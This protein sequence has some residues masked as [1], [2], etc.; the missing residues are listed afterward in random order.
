MLGR[1][2]RFIAFVSGVALAVIATAQAAPLRLTVVRL[3]AAAKPR[4]AALTP[5]FGPQTKS[6]IAKEAARE[7]GDNTISAE[8]AHTAVVNSGLGV[9]SSGDID[10]LVEAVLFQCNAD[11]EDDLRDQMDQMQKALA[12]KKSMREQQGKMKADQA[13]IAA[14]T[15]NDYGQLQAAAPIIQ[16][17]YTLDDYVAGRSDFDSDIQALQDHLDSLNDLG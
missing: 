1:R 14:Q 16:P 15:R 8:T 13:R 6:F 7:Y 9:S 4:L 2:L 17:R 3:P 10:A 11:A 12:Q 5:H